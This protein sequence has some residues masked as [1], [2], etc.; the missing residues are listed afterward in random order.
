MSTF[1]ARDLA[2]FLPDE[3]G[4]IYSLRHTGNDENLNEFQKPIPKVDQ[5]KK[6]TRYYSGK[7]PVW[8][9]GEDEGIEVSSQIDRN[10]EGSA[11]SQAVD[12][13]LARLQTLSGKE[14][15][16]SGKRRIYEAEVIL[17]NEVESSNMP[18][19]E[20]GDFI[21]GDVRIFTGIEIEE[22]EDDIGARRA[23]V[24]QRLKEKISQQAEAEKVIEQPSSLNVPQEE[25]SEYETDDSEYTDDE[26]EQIMLK[27]VFIP[28]AKRETIKEIEAKMKEEELLEKKKQLQKETKVSQTRK[29]VAESLQR[30]DEKAE[31]DATDQDSDSGIPDDTDDVDDEAE[32]E[33]WKLRELTRLK[34]DAQ[35]REAHVMEVLDLERRRGM[36]EAERLAEDKRLNI[37][38]FKV[39]EKSKWKFMQK[40]YHKGVFYMDEA[41]V[42]SSEQDVRKR[43]YNEPT[44][45]DKFDKE[46]LPEVLQVKKFGFRGRTKYTHLMDQDTTRSKAD[47]ILRP[48]EQIN[49]SYLAKRSGV[50]DIET[51]GRK[52]KKP[53]T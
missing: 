18:E 25:G 31:L 27:P 32:Y 24:L 51:A 15:Q 30:A 49:Q 19:I 7:A 17:E 52:V 38:S 1:G 43:D 26:D 40:Y 37:G 22:E 5:T 21:D 16:S 34:R 53:K 14:V 33:A 39:K 42:Q 11:P 6:V 8:A 12:R 47:E 2:L 9:E 45:E 50:G 36:T 28:R 20:D 23:R 10:P 3:V 48:I 29:L 44:L 13:R 4:D 46:K 41:S 35:E